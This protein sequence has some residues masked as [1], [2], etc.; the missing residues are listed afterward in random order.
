MRYLVTGATGFIG[1][2]LARLLMQ[3]GHRVRALVRDPEKAGDLARLGIELHR[4]D[5][6]VPESLRDPIR[7]VDGLF[8]VAGWYEVGT[9]N[10]AAA[11]RINVE[12]TRNVL[13]AMRDFGVPKGVYTSTI[14]IFSDTGG[15]IVDE[16]Y[17]HHGP[18]LSEY[19]H[20]KWI[21]HYQVA[22]PMMRRGLSLVIVQPGMVYG[23]GDT[24]ALRESL[25]QYLRR[26]LPMTPQGTAMCWAHVDD[27]AHAHLL[28][29]ERGRPG[30][31]YIIGGPVHTLRELFEIAE[32]ITGIP[33]PRWHPSPA[34]VRALA[35]LAGI[36][37]RVVRLPSSAAEEGLR[38]I[39]G[40]TYLGTNEKARREL[41]FVPRPLREGLG[42]TLLHE[43]ALLGIPAKRHSQGS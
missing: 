16:S 35:R 19:D 36:A 30:E 39:A 1:G 40:V 27:T 24:S 20:T 13:E 14:A 41:G 2:R 8:H 10:A 12:G 32:E 15:R 34:A 5:I 29:M 23:P 26:R 28:A 21:A 37:E 9:R 18:W 4:G 31:S 33:A 7:G 38:V 6:T 22:E 3:N 42:E 17:R 43:M 25:L 11:E